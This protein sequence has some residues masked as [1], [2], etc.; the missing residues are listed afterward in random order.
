MYRVRIGP[1]TQVE[2]FDRIVA[3]LKSLGIGD[4][5]LASAE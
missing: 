3:H 2:E 1:I 5:H 4:A